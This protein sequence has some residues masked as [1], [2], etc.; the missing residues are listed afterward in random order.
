ME[1]LQC[2]KWNFLHFSVYVDAGLGATNPVT[3]TFVTSGPS[4]PRTWKVKICQIPCNTIYRGKNLKYLLSS[5]MTN[6][7]FTKNFLFKAED[8]C[9][10]YFTGVSG[11]IKS[12]NYDPGAGLQLSNQDYSICVRME[13]N[14]CGIQYTACTDSGTAKN[15]SKITTPTTRKNFKLLILLP[16]LLQSTIDPIPSPYQAIV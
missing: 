9:L 4:F 7:L 5:T 1:I 15:N 3:L 8:G 16:H 14:F 10:Q 13:K 6:F 12:F 11:Q 2:K